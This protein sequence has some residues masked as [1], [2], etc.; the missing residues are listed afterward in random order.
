MAG[1]TS[2]KGGAR[3]A[4]FFWR[5]SFVS[6]YDGLSKRGTTRSLFDYRKCCT[7]A[8]ISLTNLRTKE[9][10]QLHLFMPLFVTNILMI[11]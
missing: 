10:Y 8:I 2:A 3:A 4:I 5:F 6:L 9:V 11:F 1:K 7:L